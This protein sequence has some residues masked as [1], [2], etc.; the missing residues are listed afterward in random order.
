[1]NVAPSVGIYRP[2]WEDQIP[3]SEWRVY[4]RVSE[5]AREAGIPFA[6]GGAFGTA[7]YTGELRNTKDFDFYV[8]PE[9]RDAMKEVISQAGLEDHHD[10]LPYNQSWIYR[11][12]LGDV[13]VDAIW[14]MANL[15][16]DVDHRWLSHGL[17]VTIRGEPMRA[18]PIEELIWSKLYVVQRDRSDWGDVFNLIDA[19]AE[20]VDWDHLLTRLADDAPLLTGALAVFSWLAPSRARDIPRPVWSRLGLSPPDDRDASDV[21]RY[22]AD[23][24]DSRPW[25]RQSRP[26]S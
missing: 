14:A 26:V 20:S 25:L 9:H 16:A 10:R 24:L 3:E 15:R 23:L 6:V 19:R 13:I 11:G 4:R 18:I 22:R 21:T 5:G 8:L 12:S 7:V 17:E 1:V 2:P